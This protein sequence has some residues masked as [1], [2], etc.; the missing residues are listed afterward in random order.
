MPSACTP[1]GLTANTNERRRSRNVS[2]C[3]AIQSSLAMRSRSA[4][5]ARTVP[6]GAKAR[7]PTYNASGAYHTRTS[8]A[9]CAGRPS[10]GLYDVK[11]VSTLARCQTGSSSAPSTVTVSFS[12]G[13][14]TSMRRARPEYTTGGS[15]PGAV[16]AGRAEDT[17]P[18][19]CSSSAKRT[20]SIS[21]RITDTG[22]YCAAGR[23]DVSRAG[24]SPRATPRLAAAAAYRAASSPLRNPAGLP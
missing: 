22:P 23:S 10:T 8:M 21:A 7:M 15:C 20:G 16:G 6:G 9:S 14:R 11:S 13:A 4:S 19:T 12:R 1:K 18:L 3:S 5:V 2:R 17:G 24:L